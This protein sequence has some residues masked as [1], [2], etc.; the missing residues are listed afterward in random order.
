MDG[1]RLLL[2]D[3][4]GWIETAEIDA[5]PSRHENERAI[6]GG[7]ARNAECVFLGAQSKRLLNALLAM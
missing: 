2:L 6:V 7:V 3:G 1:V 4:V 5:A